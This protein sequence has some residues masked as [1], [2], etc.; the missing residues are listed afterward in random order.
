MI[1]RLKTQK[2]QKSQKSEKFFSWDSSNPSFQFCPKAKIGNSEIRKLQDSQDFPVFNLSFFH[3]SEK[4]QYSKV[5]NSILYIYV[6]YCFQSLLKF[7][8]QKYLMFKIL[9]CCNKIYL[10][11]D[12][13]MLK[14]LGFTP[15]KAE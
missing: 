5:G 8:Q 10:F 13:S 12:V 3:F 11:W 6:M 14:R 7:L 2:P 9:P 1:V 4:F 15:C